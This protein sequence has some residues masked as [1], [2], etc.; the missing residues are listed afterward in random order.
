M[1]T[2]PVRFGIIGAGRIARRRFAP[3]LRSVDDAVLQAAASRELQRAQDLGPRTAYDSYSDLLRDPEVDAVYIATHNGLHR[4]LVLEALERGKHVLCEKPLG[5]NA[6]ECGEMAAAAEAS[7]RHL[8]EAFM[9]RYH[10][11]IA[12][13]QELVREGVIGDVTAVEASFSFHLTDENDVRLNPDWA[14]GALFDLGCYCVNFS[15]LFLG[16]TPEHVQAWAKMHPQHAVDLAFHATLQYSSG[17]HAALACSF[18][19]GM[20]QRAT[21]IG[22][23]GVIDLNNPWA[24]PLRE[25]HFTVMTGEAVHVTTLE[26]IDVFRQEIEDLCRAIRDGT[27]PLLPPTEGLL[28]ARIIDRLLRAA[29]S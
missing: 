24:S 3:A 9:Y 22:T 27:A 5:R 14:G 4:N 29:R 12:K 23:E 26:P 13:A 17:T 11:Q 19:G 6:H 25:T 1:N 8:V 28:N 15:R 20:Y 7:G 18:E 16:D 10:P 2:H 21:L